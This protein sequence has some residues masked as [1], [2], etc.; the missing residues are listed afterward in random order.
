MKRLFAFAALIAALSP[1][2]AAY[3]II[4]PSH[5]GEPYRLLTEDS[6]MLSLDGSIWY[7]KWNGLL[8]ER[9]AD[10]I[11]EV[12]GDGGAVIVSS[13]DDAEAL[14]AALAFESGLTSAVLP[15][16]SGLDAEEMADAGF[17]SMIVLSRT[18]ELEE[19]LYANEGI[20][21]IHARAGD[22]VDFEGGMPLGDD[23]PEVMVTCP[24]CGARFTMLL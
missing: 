11:Y 21:I 24:R 10:G 14:Q 17:R 3:S 9:L 8:A 16:L 4:I 2:S 19:R 1:L 18:S 22:I 13:S 20:E 5:A 6:D 15:S 7:R 23:G 12:S